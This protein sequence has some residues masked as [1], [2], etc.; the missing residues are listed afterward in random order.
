M[1]AACTVATPRMSAAINRLVRIINVSS[2]TFLE[3]ASTAAHEQLVE[4]GQAQLDPGRAPMIALSGAFGRLHFAQQRIHLGNGQAPAGAYRTVASH[5]REQLVFQ[6]L[7]A[8]R[9]AVLG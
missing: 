1:S 2:E 9:A 5:G 7:Q 3:G 8:T 4:L 6:L